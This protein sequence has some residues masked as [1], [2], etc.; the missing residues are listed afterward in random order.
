MKKTC[1]LLAL[2]AA[3]AAGAAVEAGSAKAQAK[4]GVAYVF[5]YFSDKPAG[6][7]RG[8]AAG[9]H[10]AWSADG[11]K[12]EALNGDQPVLVPAVGAKKLMRDPSICQGPDGVFHLV[13][14]TSWGDRIIGYAHSRD[15]VHW[16]EQRA[17]PVMVHEQGA[18]NCW[19]PEVTYD[20]DDGLFYI[21]WATTIPG[22]HRPGGHRIYVTTTKDW[23]TFTRAKMWFDP[24]FSA[25]DAALVRDAAAGEWLLVVK[26]ENEK[27]GSKPAEKNIRFSRTKSLAQG[28][29]DQV[30]ASISPSWV[31]GPSPLFVGDA[32][33]EYDQKKAFEGAD[34]IYAK[35]WSCPGVTRPEDYGKVLGDYHD[36][37]DWTVGERQMAVTNNAFFLHCLPV[38]RNMIVTDDVIEAPTSLVIP[39]AA[40]REISA[41]VVLKRILESL[42]K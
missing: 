13:W 20:P 26:N 18:R 30:S 3:A 34:F 37:L 21:Y 31:E 11:K 14:T 39:E 15:L 35:N 40:N 4:K 8:E 6:G 42:N 29:P 23:K 2:C 12:W 16:S 24:G 41:T 10:L 38:R 33:V 9:L 17:I 25:I 7:R 1:I 28:L 36:Y 22:R 27:S 19:A 32:C 5:S